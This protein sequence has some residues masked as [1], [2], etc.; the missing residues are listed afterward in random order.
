MKTAMTMMFVY[1][2]WLS[3]GMTLDGVITPC[4]AVLACVTSWVGIIRFDPHR[5]EGVP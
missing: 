4:M 3:V 2:F 1:A 5:L